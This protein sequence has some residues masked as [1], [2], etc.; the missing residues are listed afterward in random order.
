MVCVWIFSDAFLQ[1]FVLCFS[2]RVRSAFGNNWT[3]WL[4]P[5]PSPHPACGRSTSQRLAATPNRQRFFDSVY[6]TQL[7]PAAQAWWQD[8]RF[9]GTYCF[10]LV[11]VRDVTPSYCFNIHSY[12]YTFFYTYE[13]GFIRFMW[14]R[15]NNIGAWRRSS[16]T[17]MA[18]SFESL[19]RAYALIS[20]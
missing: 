5:R 10:A 15:F 16:N 18:V 11:F 17:K 3:S 12:A 8:K 6:E 14:L 1:P 7:E 4:R 20:W 19:C 2:L 9:R 13:P